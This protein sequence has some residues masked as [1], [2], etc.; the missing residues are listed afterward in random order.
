MCSV[1]LGVSG[2]T[3]RRLLILLTLMWSTEAIA[4][5]DR[6]TVAYWIHAFAGKSAEQNAARLNVVHYLNGIR[7]HLWWQC[8]YEVTVEQLAHGALVQLQVFEL[9]KTPVQM[10]KFME[11]TPF[12][13]MVFISLRDQG[14]TGKP[15]PC[16]N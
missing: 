11:T 2:E 5:D 9:T 14:I 12:G 3:M 15:A 4:K 16:S 6:M 7:D 1:C 13:D 8:E 10:A